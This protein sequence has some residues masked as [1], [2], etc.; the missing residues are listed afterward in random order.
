MLHGVSLTDHETGLCDWP[1]GRDR[2]A[3]GCGIAAARG[4]GKLQLATDGG[5][6]DR[7]GPL[8][9]QARHVARENPELAR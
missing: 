2:A 1:G 9:Q 4:E 5:R 8:E 7:L 3:D 6:R